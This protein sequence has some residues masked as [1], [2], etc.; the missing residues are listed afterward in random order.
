MFARMKDQ[1][2][3]T[4]SQIGH[5]NLFE[6][7]VRN[8]GQKKL[9]LCRYPYL[10]DVR[11]LDAKGKVLSDFREFLRN[12]NLIGIVDWRWVVL[13]PGDSAGFQLRAGDGEGAMDLTPKVCYAECVGF[14]YAYHEQWLSA[15]LPE[16]AAKAKAEIIYAVPLTNRIRVRR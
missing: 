16:F 4:L 13:S 14:R 15:D 12:S 8:I 9:A 1:V 2:T 7:T 6:L 10:Y 11:L 3:T 5:E